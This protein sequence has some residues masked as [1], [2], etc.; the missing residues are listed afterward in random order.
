MDQRTKKPVQANSY[1]PAG[2]SILW[3]PTLPLQ[4][5]LGYMKFLVLGYFW[6]FPL[7]IST[8]SLQICEKLLYLLQ[9]CYQ[10]HHCNL[11]YIRFCLGATHKYIRNFN[12]HF[13][14][15]WEY[16][17]VIFIFYFEYIKHHSHATTR[18]SIYVSSL[19]HNCCLES[20]QQRNF[21]LAH[22]QDVLCVVLPVQNSTR[23]HTQL[24]H[25][26]KEVF[27]LCQLQPSKE[28]KHPTSLTNLN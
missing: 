19:F 27:L 16:K 21:L 18:K 14:A 3:A 9:L 20:L 8:T 28:T 5:K 17:N 26:H 1:P 25:R 10:S 2:F 23:V 22:L 6:L 7:N 15:Q 4:S 12:L 11:I 13:S 24:E